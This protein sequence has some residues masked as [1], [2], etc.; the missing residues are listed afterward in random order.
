MNPLYET[1]VAELKNLAEQRIAERQAELKENESIA[2]RM[3]WNGEVLGIK[4]IERV[5]SKHLAAVRQSE[6]D[7]RMWQD[8]IDYLS[9]CD[10]AKAVHLSRQEWLHYVR[11][12]PNLEWC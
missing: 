1:T 2:K 9:A 11:G 10:Q 5:C 4:D 3:I 6:A 8:D 7:I 12:L